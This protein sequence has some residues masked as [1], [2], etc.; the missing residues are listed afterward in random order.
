MFLITTPKMPLK[1]KDKTRQT[2]GFSFNEEQFIEDVFCD[3][4]VLVIGSEVILNWEIEPTGDVNQ[5]LLKGFNKDHHEDFLSF[6]DLSQKL[7]NGG[8]L[9][10]RYL[11]DNIEYAEEDLSPE[12]GSL[13]QTRLFPLV[14][15]TT[16][17]GYLEFLMRK[18]WGDRL[19]I[20]N[21]EDKTSMDDLRNELR[22]CRNGE[23]YSQPT[24]FYIFGKAGKEDSPLSTFV[25]SDDDA[26]Q[27]IEKWMLLPESDAIMQLIRSK[28]L[29]TLGCKFD[30]WY[31]R[32]FWFILRR[33]IS[34]FW[35]GQ[36]AFALDECDRTDNQ[37][38]KFLTQSKIY[39]HPDA[40]AFMAKMAEMLVPSSPDSPYWS[41]SRE[42][43]N[44]G[45]IF[46]SYCNKDVTLAR[47]LFYSLQKEGYRVWF[48]SSALLGGDDYNAA[49]ANAISSSIVFIAL[50]TPNV[51]ADLAA[52]K[53]DN[54]YN[55]EWRMAGQMDGKRILPVAMDG[56]SLRAGYHQSGFENIV[57]SALSGI[58]LMEKGGF[59]ALKTTLANALNQD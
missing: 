22:S 53:T 46:I 43:K 35:E 57:G 38:A 27:I 42:H 18:V 55:R 50:L 45:G 19:R 47:Q 58:N 15:T 1:P 49:I 26:I 52:G 14:L 8:D 10:R 12:L 25:L 28:K 3:Q 29:L 48:D 20:V 17:D 40:R 32:F 4:Y 36:V 56:Y 24:L 5:Y 31:F 33:E 7:K 59:G 16:F 21:I 23:R 30:N 13:I 39:R 6:N 41:L 11:N 34:R 54:Y 37:L 51:A 2:E 44:M 9:V